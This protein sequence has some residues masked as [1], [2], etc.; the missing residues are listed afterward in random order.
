MTKQTSLPTEQEINEKVGTKI[1]SMEC[2]NTAMWV[3]G[4]AE[5]VI[6]E[7]DEEIERLKTIVLT[8]GQSTGIQYLNKDIK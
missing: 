1:Y 5:K 3:I 8:N 2:Y 6:A 4:I 7:K